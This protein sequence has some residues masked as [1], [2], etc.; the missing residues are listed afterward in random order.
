[1]KIAFD[2][3]RAFHNNTGLGHY[4]RT[5]IR[6][7]AD[8][9]PEH[10]YYLL[11]PRPSRRFA[12]KG[13]QL[14]EVRPD[15]F[16]DRVFPSYWRSFNVTKQLRRLKI[17]LYHGLSHEIP[18][19]M[20]DTAIPT[21][22]TIHDLIHERYPGQYSPVDVRIYQ[23]KF[24]Y[25]CAHSDRII[26]VSEQT[27]KDIIDFY[28]VAEN[29]IRVT[30]QSCDPAFGKKQSKEELQRVRQRYGLPDTYFLYVGSLIERK[31]LLG[32]CK[33]MHMLGKQLNVPLV[34]IGNGDAYKKKVKAYVKEKGLE[35]QVLFLSE[36]PAAMESEEFQTASVFPAIYQMASALIYP[37]SFEGFGIPVLEAL[38]SGIPVITS[39]NSSLQEVGGRGALYVDAHNTA[40]MAEAMKSI[41]ADPRLS[42]SLVHEGKLHAQQFSVKACAERVMSVY[43][44]IA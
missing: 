8:H 11:N 25:A 39:N 18:V 38:W 31:N 36:R 37:S 28:N 35:Q 13:E 27:K 43:R 20:P 42:A 3:K 34:V 2:A 32:L 41:L 23:K 15:T 6:S 1:M 5:L 14:F 30:Y 12:L 26:A 40:Q 17:E 4:S 10:A 16:I 44:E 19:G 24:R 29:K 22:V 7:L 9:F 21:V 33:A